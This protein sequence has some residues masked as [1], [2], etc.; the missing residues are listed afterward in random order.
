[1]IAGRNSDSG[2]GRVVR[3]HDLWNRSCDHHLYNGAS[4][5]KY[6]NKTEAESELEEEEKQRLKEKDTD[7]SHAKRKKKKQSKGNRK[8]KV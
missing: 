5:P 3:V 8:E 6:P 1:M 4:T 2:P 7:N